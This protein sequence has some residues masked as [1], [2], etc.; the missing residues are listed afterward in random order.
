MYLIVLNCKHNQYN[1]ITNQKSTDDVTGSS[2]HLPDDH[3]VKHS[4]TN[5]LTDFISC[6]IK[7]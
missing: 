6:S 1:E 7:F 4:V 3:F 5:Y 2:N